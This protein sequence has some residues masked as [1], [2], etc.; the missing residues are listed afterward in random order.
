MERRTHRER[1]L[2]EKIMRYFMEYYIVP[3]VN[4]KGK[5]DREYVFKLVNTLNDEIRFWDS[6]YSHEEI[7]GLFN[8]ML[9][10]YRKKR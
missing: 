9:D 5:L 1:A 10:E 4:A 6:S 7:C 2:C 3:Y 8:N